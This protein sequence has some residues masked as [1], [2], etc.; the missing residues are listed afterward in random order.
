MVLSPPFE[1]I[2]KIMGTMLRT[3]V[4]S[5]KA[6]VHWMDTTCIECPVQVRV[7]ARMGSIHAVH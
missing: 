6:F 5:S 3:I 7:T 4:E 2:H 1:E